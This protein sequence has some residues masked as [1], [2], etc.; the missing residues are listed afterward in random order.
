MQAL[1][2]ES[3]AWSG[4]HGDVRNVAENVNSMLKARKYGL[5]HNHLNR[6]S[7]GFAAASVFGTFLL[8]AVNVKQICHFMNAKV[9][10]ER[11][12]AENHPPRQPPNPSRIEPKFYNDYTG[13]L[14]E[15]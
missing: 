11:R 15:G 2:Y 14:V 4:F 5:L 9:A 8:V 12:A 6:Q 7:G 13:T 1:H 3:A 10:L